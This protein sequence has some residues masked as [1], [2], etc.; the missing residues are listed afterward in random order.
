[1]KTH[2]RISLARTGRKT[3]GR[4]LIF[5]GAHPSSLGAGLGAEHSQWRRG[6]W[7]AAVERGREQIER[8]R[9]EKTERVKEGADGRHMNPNL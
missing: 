9:V 2:S 1:M 3:V 8:G 5:R 4:E 6:R 7:A